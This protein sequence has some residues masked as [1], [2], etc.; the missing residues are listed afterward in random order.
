MHM[1][2]TAVLLIAAGGLALRLVG[3]TA[4]SPDP[5]QRLS[6]YP[7]ALEKSIQQKISLGSEALLDWQHRINLKYGQ[8]TRPIMARAN[9]PLVAKTRSMVAGLPK[10]IRGLT[11]R[12]MV[13]F[14][15]LENDW[16]TGTTEAVQDA[17][18]RWKY[19]YIALNLTSLTRTANAWGS[20]KEQSA[21]RPEA[22]YEI[23]MVLE[24]QQNDTEESAIQF[25]FLH[26]L[27]H[28]LGLALA[29]HGWWDA[30]ETPEETRNS[31]FL[32]ASWQYTDQGKMAS[33]W[34]EKFPRFSKLAFYSFHKAKLPLSAAEGLYRNLSQTNFP[35]LYGTT[36]VFDDFAE[37]FAIY[38]H[39]R[40]LGK[41][42][43]VELY[44]NGR[45]RYIYRSCITTG[46]CPEKVNALK[47]LLGF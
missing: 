25:I 9:H 24:S 20:W 6:N 8:D 31:P 43:R 28:V 18:G 22:G 10:S 29:A 44:R 47:K 46:S 37:A 11:S 16:G 41:P 45:Q 33:R 13:A 15:L 3:C 38:V 1:M 36:N 12:H 32:A 26:E 34:A 14:Y 42:Y 7:G 2:K 35:S 27:G 39:T 5:V 4:S 19:A 23:R 40:I 17:Q 30:E 21:F